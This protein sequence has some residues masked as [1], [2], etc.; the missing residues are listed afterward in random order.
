M[1]GWKLR[2]LNVQTVWKILFKKAQRS[3]RLGMKMGN[4]LI[5]SLKEILL[6]IEHALLISI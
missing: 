1:K 2:D 6:I 3:N 5:E 4:S